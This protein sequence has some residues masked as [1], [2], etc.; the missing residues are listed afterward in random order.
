MLSPI[1]VWSAPVSRKT[2]TTRL[3][4][5]SPSGRKLAATTPAA[6]SVIGVVGPDTSTDAPPKSE[7]SMPSAMAP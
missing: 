5:T 4:F 2:A 3:R 6:T 1:T 7:A